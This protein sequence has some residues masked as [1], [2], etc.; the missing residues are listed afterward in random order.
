MKSRLCLIAVL[1]SAALCL[2][3][4]SANAD[5]EGDP[6]PPCP[7]PDVQAC[8]NAPPL[9]ASCAFHKH[10]CTLSNCALDNW[11]TAC[12]CNPI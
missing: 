11:N 1:M 10:C 4:V 8:L 5:G 7:P 2:G 9:P 3:A 12:E 6:A